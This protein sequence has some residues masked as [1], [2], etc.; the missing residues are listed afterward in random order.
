MRQ[1]MKDLSEVLRNGS[2][3]EVKVLSAPAT[4]APLRIQFTGGE[5]LSINVYEV[6]GDF[7]ICIDGVKYEPEWL[8]E[9]G[10]QFTT[11]PTS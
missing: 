8:Q 5:A 10:S 7:S 3:A 9:L 4:R 11:I 2:A 1:A 6:D